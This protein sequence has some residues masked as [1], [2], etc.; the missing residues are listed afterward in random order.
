MICVDADSDQ[1]GVVF[2]KKQRF[3]ELG[4]SIWTQPVTNH[5]RAIAAGVT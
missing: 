2:F 5:G 1:R 4:W 3:H